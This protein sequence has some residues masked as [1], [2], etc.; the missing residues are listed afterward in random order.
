MRFSQAFAIAVALLAL[1]DGVI[2]DRQE[3]QQKAFSGSVVGRAAALVKPDVTSPSV[4]KRQI[5]LGNGDISVSGSGIQVLD[6]KGNAKYGASQPGTDVAGERTA[7]NNAG[8]TI[9]GLQLGGSKA[10][11]GTGNSA[12]DAFLKA[13]NGGKKNGTTNAGEGQRAGKGKGKGEGRPAANPE[14]AAKAELGLGANPGEATKEAQR[15]GE[16]ANS[17]GEEQQ[18][19]L[20]NV[21]EAA[22]PAGEGKAGEGQPKAVEESEQFKDNLG[23]TLGKDGEAQNIGGDLGITKGSDGSTSV[24]GKSGINISAGGNRK[25]GN[26]NEQDQ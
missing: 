9:G 5:N 8:L 14:E 22:K 24:G 1:G 2:C 25:Q 19:E 7:N 11:G 6:G 12:I 17:T 15:G 4:P 3:S 21:G 20:G 18:A 26:Q 13:A 16:E 10:S 23:I